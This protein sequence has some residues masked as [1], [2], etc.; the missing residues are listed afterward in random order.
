MPRAPVAMRVAQIRV[1]SRDP[2]VVLVEVEGAGTYHIGVETAGRLGLREGADVDGP[3]LTRV[4]DAASI[5]KGSVAVLRLLQR[6][7]RSR[8]EL[9]VS[10]RRYGLTPPQVTAVLIDLERAG[11]VDDRRFARLWIE[12]RMALRPKGPRALRAEL[13]VRGVARDIVDAALSGLIS[14]ERE[15]GVALEQAR[16]RVERLRGLPA[17]V[18]RRRLVGWLQRRG[19][20]AGAIA[21]ALRALHDPREE[22]SNVGSAT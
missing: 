5:R 6:R 13:R 1:S 3:L 9:A 19:F 11:W 12:D 21:R 17:D 22:G 8:A 2:S 16:R 14:P 20:G 10:L 15:D 18:V 4:N 7:L